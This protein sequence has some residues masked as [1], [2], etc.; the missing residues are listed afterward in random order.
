MNIKPIGNRV[1]VKLIKKSTTTASGII[2]A[3]EEKEEQAIGEI[4][5]IGTG[6]GTEENIKD[7]GL[8]VGQKVMFGKYTGEEIIDE[9]N[10]DATMKILSGKDL[11]AIID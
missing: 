5:S 3:T 11:I 9:D 10:Q 4:V 1:V 7:L 2:V 6:Y 8:S